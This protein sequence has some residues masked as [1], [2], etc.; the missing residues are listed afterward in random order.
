VSRFAP[1]SDALSSASLG[2]GALALIALATQL[3]CAAARSEGAVD[4]TR[5]CAAAHALTAVTCAAKG[6]HWVDVPE[7]NDAVIGTVYHPERYSNLRH[8]S[9]FVFLE[10]RAAIDPRFAPSEDKLASMLREVAPTQAN[11]LVR[12]LV[13]SNAHVEPVSLTQRNF[14][15][16]VLL[17]STET[18]QYLTAR[19]LADV[20]LVV[21]STLPAVTPGDTVPGVLALSRPGVDASH[22]MAVVI[23]VLRSPQS[24]AP[25]HV[26]RASLVLAQRS[27]LF[28]RVT[29]EWPL[30]T[31]KQ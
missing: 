8:P 16:Q 12:S 31:A 21:T 26:E 1:S 27:G 20:P 18:E 9:G 28:W 30:A 25:D 11:A 24:L 17:D 4:C 6:A 7:L 22:S 19:T 13:D 3:L 14:A 10:S 2:A 23:A 29:H 5:L 15:E